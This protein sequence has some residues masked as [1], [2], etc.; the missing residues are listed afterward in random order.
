MRGEKRS[1]FSIEVADAFLAG[2]AVVPG[3]VGADCG[4]AISN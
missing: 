2:K 4:L 3:V 1:G